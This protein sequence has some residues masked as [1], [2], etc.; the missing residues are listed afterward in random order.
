MST[1]VSKLQHDNQAL[2]H[3]IE[4]KS[5]QLRN[6]A[7]ASAEIK[8]LED[9]GDEY[10]KKIEL[11]RRRVDELDKQ[12][13]IAQGKLDEQRKKTG[14][15]NI[16]KQ[17]NQSL[18][19]QTKKLENRLENATVRYNEVLSKNKMIK[20]AID[21][22][23]KER[24]IYDGIYKK[25]ER[26]TLEEQKLMERLCGDCKKACQER[27]TMK[28]K[29]H[30]LK[31]ESDEENKKFQKEWKILND[32]FER[33]KKVDLKPDP[34]T[35][36]IGNLTATQEAALKSRFAK[37][38]WQMG[39]DKISLT[40]SQEKKSSYEEKFNA[41]QE[42]IGV[43][44]IKELVERFVEAEQV[45]FDLFNDVA[46][47]NNVYSAGEYECNSLRSQVEKYRGD[48]S[49]AMVQQKAAVVG[50][51]AKLSVDTMKAQTLEQMHTNS[52]ILLSS[53]IE[54]MDGLYKEIED[55]TT[56]P[57]LFGGINEGNVLQYLGVVEQKAFE[58]LDRFAALTPGDT[59][60]IHN[61]FQNANQPSSYLF[62]N[63]SYM[64][65]ELI[66]MQTELPKSMPVGT[67]V[68]DIVDD[69]YEDQDESDRPYS[70]AELH[71][72]MLRQL[73]PPK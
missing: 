59:N 19:K 69:V 11:E 47:L 67:M 49:E 13:K 36:K 37:K 27:D 50:L 22:S 52:Q 73:D 23:R 40:S 33:D 66:N 18:G 63:S 29:L 46:E 58:I 41:I 24:I 2:E 28:Y 61:I 51:Q 48:D 44:D 39:K 14:G 42:R 8:R 62:E 3:A 1:A 60:A 15:T 21:S 57:D 56:Q 17:T 38:S 34:E 55:D 7:N 68:Q 30:L 20:E 53:I 5:Q 32:R 31:Q 9:Q 6:N 12:I 70:K 65:K 26:D 4:T 64:S 25:M 10:T 43:S 54:C 35:D 72:Q 16:V 45:N 71:D